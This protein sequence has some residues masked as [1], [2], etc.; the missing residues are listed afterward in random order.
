MKILAIEKEMEGATWDHTEELLEQEA[1]HVFRA[2]LTGSLREIY[3]TEEKLAVLI[4][5]TLDRETA[6]KIL[7]SLP[8]VQ[9]GKIQFEVMELLPYTGYKRIINDAADH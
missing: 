4:L 5:E 8:L 6:E 9:S 3:F 7:D 2:Y 1:H